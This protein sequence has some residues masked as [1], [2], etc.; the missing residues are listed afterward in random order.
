MN[1]THGIILIAGTAGLN[2]SSGRERKRP[3]S[4][5]HERDHPPRGI[6][7]RKCGMRARDDIICCIFHFFWRE[8]TVHTHAEM[9]TLVRFF[10][11]VT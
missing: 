2:R 9:L 5:F 8:L 3:W 11:D 7:V 6:S 4:I 1:R 10:F